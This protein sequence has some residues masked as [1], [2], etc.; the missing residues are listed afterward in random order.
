MRN[1]T[2]S[3]RVSLE[4]SRLSVGALPRFAY[5]LDWGGPASRRRLTTAGGQGS[6]SWRADRR[7]P[8]DSRRSGVVDTLHQIGTLKGMARRPVGSRRRPSGQP[9][10]RDAG[11]AL[12]QR[13]ASARRSGSNLVEPGRARRQAPGRAQVRPRVCVCVCVC[14]FAAPLAR[15]ATR[16][17]RRPPSTRWSTGNEGLLGRSLSP[18][19]GCPAVACWSLGWSLIGR[20]N[21]S[22]LCTL[23]GWPPKRLH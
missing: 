17:A 4:W 1:L 19:D 22:S 8:V 13:R 10:A 16:P 11:P 3:R 7:P 23:R 14:R 20:D 12:A 15:S 6:S 21:I 5:R 9:G 2:V 18:T